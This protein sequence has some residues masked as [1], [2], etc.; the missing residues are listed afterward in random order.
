MPSE[1]VTALA[2]KLT[3]P[4][5]ALAT[6]WWIFLI[7]VIL[8]FLAVAYGYYTVWGSGISQTPYNDPVGPPESPSDLAHDITQDVGNWERGTDSGRRRPPPA[9]RDP[10]DPTVAAALKEW[11][12]APAPEPRL[13]PPVGSDDHV[14]GPA[15]AITV[16]VYVDVTSGPSRNAVRLLASLARQRP[17]R[18]AVRH[19][20]LADVHHLALPAAEALEAAGAQGSFF[21]LLDRLSDSNLPDEEALMTAARGC[22]ADPE[23]LREELDAGR[24]RSRIVDQ[25]RQATSSGARGVP[26]IYIDGEHFAGGVT[27]DPLS[28]A[29]DSRVV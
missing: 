2:G 26:E 16:A 21:D 13:A 3:A 17:L 12:R 29:L 10:V 6:G 5:L 4:P 28:R 15:D 19:L 9:V 1:A 27:V 23:R 14:R 25:I 18:V 20:P 8:I 24:Y 22:V 7:V 11:R